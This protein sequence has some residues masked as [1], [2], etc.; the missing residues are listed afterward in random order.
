MS[1]FPIS[2]FIILSSLSPLSSWAI[3]PSE[4]ASRLPK[5]TYNASA[6]F[7][8]TMPQL[9][10]DVVYSLDISQAASPADSLLPIAYLIDWTITQRPG[11][12][13]PSPADKGFNAYI[14]GSYY[15]LMAERLRERHFSESP[16]A[17]LAPR[18]GG[19]A[20]TSQFAELLPA[21][22]ADHIAQMEADPRY[23][24][25][26]IAD[27][28]VD[29]ET[30]T[31]LL[32]TMSSGGM[33]GS[34]GEYIF[35]PDSILSPRRI[36]LE[37]N[38]GSIGEQTITVKYEP[39]RPDPI[40]APLNEDE[41]I[42]RFPD[43]FEAFRT[44]TY[45]LESLPGRHLPAMAARTLSGERFTRSAS[46]ALEAPAV[47]VFLDA[48]GEFTHR[49]IQDVRAAKAMLPYR[50]DIIWAFVD[51]NP[52]AV[53]AV[54]TPGINETALTS[55]RGLASNC[56]AASTIPSIVFTGK[57]GIVND[58]IAGFNKTFSSDVIKKMM[59]LTP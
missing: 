55:S 32:F 46:Q 18:K 49:V 28:I 35:Y 27:T 36:T 59:G 1:R 37:N 4:I 9:P 47:I 53:A 40:P 39:P 8:V 24:L 29:G 44:S 45:R 11:M 2:L 3:T 10:D 43:E 26:A 14:P 56:G 33:V 7:S 58:Y 12:D 17:F 13:S 6:T 51:T 57:D 54:V 48:K 50:L 38:T 20:L 34:E 23:S 5:D 15:S 42:A 21:I 25:T 52:D 30:A 22:I 16:Q 41:L 31:A 19:V